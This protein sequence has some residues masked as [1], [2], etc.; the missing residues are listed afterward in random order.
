MSDFLAF[1]LALLFA[2][3]VSARDAREIPTVEIAPTVPTAPSGRPVV[4]TRPLPTIPA[5]CADGFLLAEDGSCV[6]TGFY[7]DAPSLSDVIPM[8]PLDGLTG[9]ETCRHDVQLSGDVYD[10]GSFV[11][12]DQTVTYDDG[13]SLPW[14]VA[15]V[16][17]S[18][19]RSAD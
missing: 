8:C 15:H 17:L 19:P 10:S 13:L 11:L 3:I 9:G 12:S 5:P 16:W 4:E 6:P 18:Q 1:I 7:D 14:S 2:L